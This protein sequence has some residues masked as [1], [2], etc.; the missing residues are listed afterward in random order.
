MVTKDLSDNGFARSFSLS[1]G[2]RMS[3]DLVVEGEARYLFESGLIGAIEAEVTAESTQRIDD[4]MRK[5]GDKLN[6]E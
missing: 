6:D 1:S 2:N 3:T 4:W 5:Y